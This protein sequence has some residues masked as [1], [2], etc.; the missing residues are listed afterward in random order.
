MGVLADGTANMK[1]WV[2]AGQAGFEEQF[3][4]AE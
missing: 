3:G 4:K 1:A 2:G